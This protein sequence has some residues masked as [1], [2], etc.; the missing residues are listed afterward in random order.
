MVDTNEHLIH[1]ICFED[2]EMEVFYANSAH[3]L[4]LHEINF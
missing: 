2:N 1:S 4:S 3:V